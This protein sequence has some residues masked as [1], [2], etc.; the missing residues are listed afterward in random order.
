MEAANE[1]PLAGSDVSDDE[2]SAASSVVSGSPEEEGQQAPEAP[3]SPPTHGGQAAMQSEDE[4]REEAVNPAQSR[5]SDAS[6]DGAIESEEEGAV[7]SPEPTPQLHV[8][9]QFGCGLSPLYPPNDLIC[10]F[11][12]TEDISED[13]LEAAPAPVAKKPLSSRSMEPLEGEL[14]FEDDAPSES[15]SVSLNKGQEDKDKGGDKTKEDNL[16]EGE[17]ED[18]GEVSDVSGD[19]DLEEG[20]LPD[21]GTSTASGV[22]KAQ[23][24]PICRFFNKGQCTWGSLCRFIHPGINDR[25]NYNMF[26]PPPPLPMPMPKPH[27]HMPPLAPP[28]NV[29]RG[30]GGVPPCEFL[31]PPPPPEELVPLVES[32]W[33]RGLRHAKEL[34]KRA[35]RRK[36]QEPDFEEK[37]LN[38]GPE[39]HERAPSHLEVDK[40]NEFY[41]PAGAPPPVPAR[42][43]ALSPPYLARPQHPPRGR[44]TTG[45]RDDLYGFDE[46]DPLEH[47]EREAREYWR[48]GRYENFQVRWNSRHEFDP[49]DRREKDRRF[50]RNY[51]RENVFP[52]GGGGN[53]GGYSHGGSSRMERPHVMEREPRWREERFTE[54]PPPPSARSRPDEW[55]DP[56]RR[57]KTPKGRRSRSGGRNRRSFSNCSSRSFSSRSSRSSYSYSRSSSS[58]SSFYSSESR[59]RS[60]SPVA[61]APPGRF[62]GGQA[63]SRGPPCYGPP[64]QSPVGKPGSRQGTTR[65]SPVLDR[66]KAHDPSPPPIT[67][68]LGAPRGKP[69]RKVPSP[70]SGKL[71]KSRSGSF[72]GSSTRSHSRTSSSR[73]PSRSRSRSYS[74]SLSINSVSSASSSPGRPPNP[75]PPT[76]PVGVAV[77]RNPSPPKKAVAAVAPEVAKK[78]VEKEVPKPVAP[79]PAVMYREPPLPPTLDLG[80]LEEELAHRQAKEPPK[81]TSQKPQI[82]LT[83]IKK[84]LPLSLVKKEEPA[85]KNNADKGPKKRPASPKAN[86]PSPPPG[87]R[88]STTLRREELLKQLKAV[89]DAIARK[90]AKFS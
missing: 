68:P 40:E 55:R 12:L 43:P 3:S 64:S 19:D 58:R 87:G 75:V 33:E 83:L 22:R 10:C 23:A 41:A 44:R 48:G 14:D 52:V 20:E 38:L 16:E 27:H 21:G 76:N 54:A 80:S 79:P 36:E 72:S 67:A 77:A 35:S 66:R 74:R 2:G 78:R 9:V 49:R 4:G 71:K 17:A 29:M 59:S 13:A 65:T 85:P 1:E 63:P 50:G 15:P 30:S 51:D 86:S 26:A 42:G 90:R 62:R 5:C 73:T 47:S 89:E 61:P 60:R 6:Q 34:M 7:H 18:D 11:Q 82:K 24:R 56:W 69:R 70:P 8:S 53:G 46:P 84:A 37:R 45:S 25:G 32:A 88:K 31:P 81:Q 57:S 28:S 39:T